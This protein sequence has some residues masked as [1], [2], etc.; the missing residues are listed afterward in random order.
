VIDIAV[1]ARDARLLY[2]E[3]VHR[4]DQLAELSRLARLESDSIRDVTMSLTQ[5]A[6]VTAH[7]ALELCRY[8]NY[9]EAYEL[10]RQKYEEKM[11][12]SDFLN[13]ITRGSDG[14]VSS[15]AGETEQKEG[16]SLLRLH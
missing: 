2:S 10:G 15:A 6:C 3:A 4:A 12:I 14:G 1:C 9:S 5:M 13:V 16:Q 11:N 7:A 8:K